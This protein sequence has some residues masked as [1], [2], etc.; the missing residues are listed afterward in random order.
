MEFDEKI[1][2]THYMTLFFN[3]VPQPID[4]F[5]LIKIQEQVVSNEIRF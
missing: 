4:I 5:C 2:S 1:Q 3:Y